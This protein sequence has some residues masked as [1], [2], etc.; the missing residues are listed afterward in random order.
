[1]MGHAANEGVT[2][3]V[4]REVCLRTGSKAVLAGSI[5]DLRGHYLLELIAVACGDGE[6]LVQERREAQSRD[7]VLKALSQASFSL[8]ARLGESS[9]SVQ[10][11][12]VPINVTTFSLEALKNYRIGS[13]CGATRAIRRVFRI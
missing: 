13:R 1:M 3:E 8:R 10:E 7:D 9:A 2:P 12:A 11:F 6:T 5:A 4:D